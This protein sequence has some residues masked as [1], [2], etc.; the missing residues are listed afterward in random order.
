MFLFQK[1]L[2]FL[3]YMYNKHLIIL[4]NYPFQGGTG[5]FVFGFILW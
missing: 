5:Y 3:F 4:Q 2:L 1:S